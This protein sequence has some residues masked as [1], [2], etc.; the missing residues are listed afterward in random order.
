LNTNNEEE[1]MLAEREK[2]NQLVKEKEEELRILKQQQKEIDER[3]FS[4]YFQCF[5]SFSSP[6]S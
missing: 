6:S 5:S 1:E 4:K 3:F 2:I